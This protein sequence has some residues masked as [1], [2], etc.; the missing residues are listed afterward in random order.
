MKFKIHR[1]TKEIGGSCIEVWTDSTRIVLDFG[2]PLVD[3]KRNPFDSNATNDCEVDELIHLGVL[4]RIEGLYSKD[5][6]TALILS[7]AHQ[8]HYGLVEYIHED[9]P[10]FMG[11]PTHKL[12]ELTNTFTRNKWKIHTS[13]YFS[14]GKC[15]KFG[16]IEIT[17]YLMD[18]AAFDAHA[19]L[20]QANGKSLF[21]SGD[22]R[23]HGRKAKAFDWFKW[24]VKKDVDYLLLEG[25]TI[26]RGSHSFP[27]E[28]DLE[29]EFANEFKTNSGIH[30]VYVSGQNIDRLVSLYR[31]C[32]KENKILAIDFYI[33]TVLK[34]LAKFARL[35]YPSESFPE[36]RVFYPRNLSKMIA[37]QGQE[38]LLYQFKP[39]KITKEQINEQAPKV[40]MTIR[41]S[42]KSDLNA[43]TCL[44]GGTFIYSMWSGYREETVIY[45]FI[46]LLT[47]QGMRDVTIHTSGHADRQGLQRM[48]DALKP[49][50][51][52]PIH[53]FDANEYQ[54]IFSSS[55]VLMVDDGEIVSI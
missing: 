33:A 38:K 35:P 39:Y 52:V 54:S 29:K 32:K 40:V 53:T 18:H 12:I 2:M 51:L 17:P 3:E 47:G 28:E 41:P 42:M 43:L 48:V 8:D 24:N 7:H 10:I 45:D 21:Y 31:A 9:C 36:I 49:K 20:V 37:N 1:G 19:F 23:I 22:F 44:N 34:E 26:N 30:L 14:S 15:F 25:T 46:Q 50:K 11:E 6:H 16:D 13:N 4:P 5:P 55:E 27:T